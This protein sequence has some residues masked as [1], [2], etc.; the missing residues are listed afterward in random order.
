MKNK[1]GFT[2]IELMVVI[3]IIGVLSLMG[4]RVYTGQQE[5]AK[6]AIVKANAGTI[7]T[8]LQANMADTDYIQVD[9]GDRVSQALTDIANAGGCHNPYTSGTG[10]STIKECEESLVGGVYGDRGK[11]TI[12]SPKKN[13]FKIQGLDQEGKLFGTELQANK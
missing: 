5:K 6:N 2:L 11:V 10:V 9:A 13:E 12:A 1:K 7:Q 3:A 8:L 4:L